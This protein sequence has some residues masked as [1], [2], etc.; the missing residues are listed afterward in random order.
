[1]HTFITDEQLAALREKYPEGTRVELIQMDDEY[2]T[3]LEPGSL[4]TVYGVD[5][6]GNVLVNWDCGSSLSVLWGIDKIKLAQN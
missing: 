3:L 4:G 2:N 5:E 1:M 6:T